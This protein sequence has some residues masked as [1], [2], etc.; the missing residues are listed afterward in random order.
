MQ[1]L[2]LYDNGTLKRGDKTDFIWKTETA[3]GVTGFKAMFSTPLA[4]RW[5][6]FKKLLSVNSTTQG[7]ASAALSNFRDNVFL[8]MSSNVCLLISYHPPHNMYCDGDLVLAQHDGKLPQLIDQSGSI[9]ADFSWFPGATKLEFVNHSL[10]FDT[11][12][13]GL[14]CDGWRRA[15]PQHSRYRPWVK[16]FFDGVPSAAVGSYTP[17]AAAIRSS[18]A[19][20]LELVYNFTDPCPVSTAPVDCKA[21]WVA[22]GECMA[23]GL[24]IWRYTVER[25]AENGGAA[26]VHADGY[27]AMKS[28]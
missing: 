5:P 13:I 18:M 27:V 28:C 4:N 16:R 2:P 23:S 25:H 3:L 11:T 8:N 1:D 21:I 19:S 24:Q 7:W 20:G 9:E 15:L 14:R 26:C 6:I 12:A 10:G 17:A 22:W